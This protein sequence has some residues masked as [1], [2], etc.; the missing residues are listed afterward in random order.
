MQAS[1]PP[2]RE[3]CLDSGASMEAEGS[4]VSMRALGGELQDVVSSREVRPGARSL[5][6]MQI[7]PSNLS[8]LMGFRFCKG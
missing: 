5:C 4:P 7:M 1:V 3:P 8:R 2:R 6:F